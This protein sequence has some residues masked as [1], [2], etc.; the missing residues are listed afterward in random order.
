M[1][2]PEQMMRNPTRSRP[3]GRLGSQTFFHETVRSVFLLQ[4]TF[5][6]VTVPGKETL[7]HCYISK[8]IFFLHCLLIPPQREK[9]EAL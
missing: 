9:E 1:F 8:V 3:K 4:R 7:S 2:L 5:R 6:R